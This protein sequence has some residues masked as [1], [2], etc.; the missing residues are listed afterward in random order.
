MRS[1]EHLS[2]LARE[3]RR[4]AS[5]ERSARKSAEERQLARYFEQLA[6]A[7]AWLEERRAFGGQ[8]CGTIRK[9]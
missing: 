4:R 7:E 6:D 9:P 2:S 5:N 8:D 1:S 3:A